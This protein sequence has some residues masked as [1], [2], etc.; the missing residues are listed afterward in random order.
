[1]IRIS[2][3]KVSTE[4]DGTKKFY[5]TPETGCMNSD[6][7]LSSLSLVRTITRVIF[8]MFRT[9]ITHRSHI[10]LSPVVAFACFIQS[11]ASGSFFW[12]F[13]PI[14][15]WTIHYLTIKELVEII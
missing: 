14:K 2:F 6:L 15:P 7:K 13:I 5:Y 8:I 10:D 3:R 9:I 12:H 4:Y 11:M 1:M